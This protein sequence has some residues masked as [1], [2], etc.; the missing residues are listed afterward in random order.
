MMHRLFAFTALCVALSAG[1]GFAA[2]A[3]KGRETFMRVGC[4][5]CHGTLG[6]GGAAGPKLA[7]NPMPLAAMRTYIR[8]PA[9][10]MPPYREP[11]LPDADIADIHAYLTSVPPPPRLEDTILG[12][13]ANAPPAR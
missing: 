6:Q 2:D 10:Q 1:E 8:A 13:A 9:Q 12:S 3:A 5:T 11:S 7:P 4:Y